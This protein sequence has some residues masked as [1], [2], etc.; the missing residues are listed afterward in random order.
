MDLYIRPIRIGGNGWE[1]IG[2]SN[3]CAPSRGIPGGALFL[4]A[5]FV[6]HALVCVCKSPVING[7]EIFCSNIQLRL[8]LKLNYQNTYSMH[9]AVRYPT[10]TH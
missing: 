9:R 2:V 6:K 1:I 3:L 10:L 7:E 4:H 5:P 8:F